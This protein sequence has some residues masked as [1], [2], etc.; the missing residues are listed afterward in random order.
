MEDKDDKSKAKEKQG[1]LATPDKVRKRSHRRDNSGRER[2]INPS[3]FEKSK[4]IVWS[5]G[6]TELA[7]LPSCK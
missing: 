7:D 1:E 4:Y 5:K 6:R 2:G 3:R